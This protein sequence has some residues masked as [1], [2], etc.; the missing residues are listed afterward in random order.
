MED[1]IKKNINIIIS[2]FIL[3][4]PVLDVLTGINVHYLSIPITIGMLVRILFLLGMFIVVF[5]FYQKKRSIIPYIIVGIF[6]LFFLFGIHSNYLKEIQ[7]FVKTFYFPLL[8]SNLYFIKEDI[9]ISK[10]TLF[11]TLFLYLI[12][13]F[14]PLLLGEGYQSYEITK[15]GTLGF[16]HS[17]NEISGIIAILTPVMFIVLKKSNHYIPKIMLLVMYLTVI[18]MMGTKTPLLALCFVIGTIIMY[19][20]IHWFQQKEMKKIGISVF[21]LLFG[22]VFLYFIL[23]KTNFYKNIETHLDFLGVDNVIEVFGDEKLIDH[24]IFSQRLTFLHQTAEVY[25]NSNGYQKLFGIGTYLNGQEMKTIEMDY[26]DIYYHYGL[27]GFLVFFGITLIPLYLILIE[28]REESFDRYMVRVSLLLVI[29]LSLFVGHI[30]TAPSV[31]LIVTII[32]LALNDDRSINILIVGSKITKRQQKIIDEFRFN[33]MN[34][35]VKTSI[36]KNKIEF[37]MFKI[38]HYNNYDYSIYIDNK[39]GNGREIASIGSGV[40]HMIILEKGKELEKKLIGIKNNY[41]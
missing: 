11:T 38:L 39:M 27:I 25:R 7:S 40:D 19:Y 2:A 17:A 8:L 22:I 10:L 23:P 5:F 24:F 33:D 35:T 13:I 20:W 14:V 29:F 18:L 41:E 6:S 15:A 31:S 28:E 37:L 1:Y 34:I 32:I 12:F 30:I 16:Y 36:P 21:V 4:S 3:I 26:F 9:H